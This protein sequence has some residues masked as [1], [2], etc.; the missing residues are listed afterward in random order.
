MKL[1]KK[2]NNIKIL[3]IKEL[4]QLQK[5]STSYVPRN[6]NI[7]KSFTEVEYKVDPEASSLKPDGTMVYRDANSNI[8][9]EESPSGDIKFYPTVQVVDPI[10]QQIQ[11]AAY[12]P[13]STKSNGAVPLFQPRHT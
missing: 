9:A 3:S 13:D 2:Q 8:L 6:Y 4:F 1:K 7:P 12:H 5:Q 10:I 11:Q